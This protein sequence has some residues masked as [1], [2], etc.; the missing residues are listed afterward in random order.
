MAYPLPVIRG[1]RHPCYH[2]DQPSYLLR[3]SFSSVQCKYA[4]TG[5]LPVKAHHRFLLWILLYLQQYHTRRVVLLMRYLLPLLPFHQ[6][7]HEAVSLPLSALSLP[8]ELL[9]RLKYHL[10]GLL[11]R[12]GWFHA[13]LMPLMH[14]HQH[15]ERLLW[16]LPVLIWYHALLLHILPYGWMYTHH[17]VLNARIII[18]H[19]RSYNLPMS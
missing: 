19:P 9:F 16:S 7:S 2:D 3:K 12:Y 10:H 13:R 17:P 8:L 14:H 15:P 6:R 4:Q 5:L 18:Q 1:K 11:H